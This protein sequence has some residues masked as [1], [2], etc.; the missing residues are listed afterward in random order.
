MKKYL[1]YLLIAI[2]VFACESNYEKGKKGDFSFRKCA[3]CG[4]DN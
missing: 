2:F 4:L 3:K 1:A